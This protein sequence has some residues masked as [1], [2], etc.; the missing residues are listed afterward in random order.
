MLS[1]NLIILSVKDI[2]ESKKFYSMLGFNFIKEQHENSPV[3]YASEL[4]GLVMELYPASN[5]F[6]LEKSIRLGFS[7]KNIH[8]I[9]KALVQ[10]NIEIKEKENLIIIEDPDGRKIYLNQKEKELI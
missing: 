7:V 2:E 9:K 3:H 1:F 6:P 5:R 4:N 8:E 10:H